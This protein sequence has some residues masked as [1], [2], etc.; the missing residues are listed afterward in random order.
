MYMKAKVLLREG[1]CT[2]GFFLHL[3]SLLAVLLHA[4]IWVQ[5]LGSRCDFE[6]CACTFG[7]KAIGNFSDLQVYTWPGPTWNAA[8]ALKVM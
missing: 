5:E 6:C 1:A 4:S 8:H 3:T 7:H 2:L